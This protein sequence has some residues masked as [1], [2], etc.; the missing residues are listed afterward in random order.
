MQLRQMGREN[1]VATIWQRVH[2]G[3]RRKARCHDTRAVRVSVVFYSQQLL[4][5]KTEEVGG[6][7]KETN[8]KETG[9][10]DTSETGIV[11]VRKSPFG[12]A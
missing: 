10:D 6:K 11:H 2:R 9:E 4:S 8:D 1:R 5:L 7:K 3:V 12:V